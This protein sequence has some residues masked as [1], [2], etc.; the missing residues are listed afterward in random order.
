MSDNQQ[1][2]KLSPQEIKALKDKRD[3]LIQTQQIIKK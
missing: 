1:S 3:K 2:K